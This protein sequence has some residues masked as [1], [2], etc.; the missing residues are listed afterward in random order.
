MWV[1]L[2][3]AWFPFGVLFLVYIIADNLA[4]GGLLRRVNHH[5]YD[6]VLHAVAYA[7]LTLA[8]H[9]AIR[10]G[11]PVR[12]YQWAANA[13]AAIMGGF[14][15]LSELLQAV[16]VPGHNLF[17][18]LGVDVGGITA[19]LVSAGAINAVMVRRAGR[20]ERAR[21]IRLAASRRL[22]YGPASTRSS[23]RD[24]RM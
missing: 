5:G 10:L 13:S 11:P 7:A 22:R 12:P 3:A 23:D 16:S 9:R 8:L 1:R 20:T 19:A 6:K 24:T 14:G 4:P 21:S 2:G 18:H 15:A 17:A